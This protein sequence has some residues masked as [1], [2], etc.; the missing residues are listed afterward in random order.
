MG[1]FACSHLAALA[2]DCVPCQTVARQAATSS[3]VTLVCPFQTAFQ[4]PLSAHAFRQVWQLTVRTAVGATHGC[5]AR[6]R[7]TTRAIAASKYSGADASTLA[8]MLGPLCFLSVHCWNS[9]EVRSCA[10]S[11]L[12][13]A[14]QVAMAA[15]NMK[16]SSWALLD[17]QRSKCL[18]EQAGC[19]NPWLATRDRAAYNTNSGAGST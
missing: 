5:R 7:S 15:Q 18:Q 19:M 4:V 2:A 8:P 12:T 13:I 9:G 16:M 10:S 3:Q 17:Q 11:C 1:K 14:A 6:S